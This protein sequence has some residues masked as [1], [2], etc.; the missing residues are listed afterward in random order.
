MPFGFDR[1]AEDFF[2]S[3]KAVENPKVPLECK[4][5]DAELF[6][7]DKPRT[8]VPRSRNWV[9]H[10]H[11]NLAVAGKDGLAVDLQTSFERTIGRSDPPSLEEVSGDPRVDLLPLHVIEVGLDQR[12]EDARAEVR[13]G[14]GA[15]INRGLYQSERHRPLQMRIDRMVAGERRHRFA[16]DRQPTERQHRQQLAALFR[17]SIQQELEQRLLAELIGLLFQCGQDGLGGGLGI[18]FSQRFALRRPQV[19]GAHRLQQCVQPLEQT[20]I[21]G[22]K[23][24]RLFTQRGIGLGLRTEGGKLLQLLGQAGLLQSAQC[25]LMQLGQGRYRGEQVAGRDDHPA[26]RVCLTNRF[27]QG[28]E[29]LLGIRLQHRPAVG[30]YVDV[31][32]VV[33]LHVLFEVIEH[34]QNRMAAQMLFQQSPQPRFERQSQLVHQGDR[35][36]R[37]ELVTQHAANL[38]LV[39]LADA[40]KALEA[41]HPFT[42]P[43][44]QAGFA[45]PA[46][47]V[48]NQ[49]VAVVGIAL[50]TTQQPQAPLNHTT[51]AD[52]IFA[53]TDLAL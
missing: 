3:C 1:L 45:E 5:Q 42:Q 51:T 29:C 12:C 53:R 22:T 46:H 19:A 26:A 40:D 13:R 14:L 28:A 36:D 4:R 8:V 34:E 41:R 16:I 2:G 47:A 39:D 23:V 35:L 27:D 17:L 24:N 7:L 18:V 25:L 11:S 50:N 20:R 33:T 43:G 37:I 10:L 52:E 38:G 30:G 6:C 49:A 15:L 32:V 21:A 9:G 31:V 48:E 44:G